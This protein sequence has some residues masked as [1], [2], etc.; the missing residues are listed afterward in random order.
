MGS[1]LFQIGNAIAAA[2][3]INGNATISSTIEKL[4]WNSHPWRP[5]GIGGQYCRP[6]CL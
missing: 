6:S 5:P 4:L 1:N 3:P 2:M